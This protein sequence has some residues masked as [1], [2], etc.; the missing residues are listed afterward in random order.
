MDVVVLDWTISLA[1]K[2]KMRAC[3]VTYS[4]KEANETT[5][6]D[7]FMPKTRTFLLEHLHPGQVS[8]Y[9]FL[10][11]PCEVF[12]FDQTLF[13]QMMP[14]LFR[15]RDFLFWLLHVVNNELI[16]RIINFNQLIVV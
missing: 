6:V 2:D 13:Y 9:F 4:A 8:N 5:T 10:N 3:A 16:T 15:P 11:Y 12:F 7:P 1:D 14:Y